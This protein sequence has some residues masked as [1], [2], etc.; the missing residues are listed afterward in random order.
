[1]KL[2]VDGNSIGD[3]GARY[4]VELLEVNKKIKFSFDGN[5]I[6]PDLENQLKCLN[7]VRAEWKEEIE[8]YSDVLSY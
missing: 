7:D 1:M 6:C 5:N 4:M 3:E 8:D 2:I